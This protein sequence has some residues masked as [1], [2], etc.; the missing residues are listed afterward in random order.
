MPLSPQQIVTR[1][2]HAAATYDA[3]SG[4]QRAMADDLLRRFDPANAKRDSAI[5]DLGCGTGY[6]MGQLQNLGFT[7]LHGFD[8]AREMIEIAQ[9]GTCDVNASFTEADLQSLPVPRQTFDVIFSNAAIQWCDT[10]RAATEINRVL[11][12]GGSGFISTFGP[13]TLQQ[14]KNVF[15]SHGHN[16]VHSFAA[17]EQLTAHFK[18]SGLTVSQVETRLQT[19]TFHTVKEMFDSI[20]KLGA[21]NAAEQRKPIKK[22]VYQ[23]IQKTFQQQLVD[24]GTLETT[25]ETISMVVLRVAT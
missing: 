6:L 2:N 15:Q 3:V 8:I 25:F 5:G 7:N 17:P 14:W 13:R 11:R 23:S 10:A 9:A 12:P 16:S 24:N 19:Q 4:L 18:K 1:F 21:S 22:S 20:R